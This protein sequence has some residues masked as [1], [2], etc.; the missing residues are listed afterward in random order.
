MKSNTFALKLLLILSLGISASVIQAEPPR[1][2]HMPYILFEP[3]PKHAPEERM[4]VCSAGG[5]AV[6]S[7]GRLWASWDSGDYGEGQENFILLATSGDGGHTWSEPK[8]IID[9]PF[10]ASYSMVWIDPNGRMWFVFNIWPIRSAVEDQVGMRERFDDIRSF[11]HFI[12]TYNFRAAQMW[13]ITTDNP[14]DEN[15]EWSS[16]RLIA[17]EVA[18][19]MNEPTVLSDG[20]WV[21]P[22]AP[23]R[24]DDFPLRPLFSSDEG[25]TFHFRG[26][27][28]IPQEEWN[29]F[30]N[31]VV[32]R[33]DGSLWLLTRI[34]SGIGESISH[35]QGKTWTPIR[36]PD[37]IAH[38]TSRLYISRLQSGNLLLVKHGDIM[39]RGR[40]ENLKAFIS[41]DDGKTWQGGFM[42]DERLGVTYPDGTQDKDGLIYVLY[43]Y[44]RHGAKEIL[45]AV[46]TEEDVLA[47]QAVS[48]KVRLR[49]VVDKALAFNP[50][51]QRGTPP[52]RAD[53]ILEDAPA[54]PRSEG[55]SLQTGPMAVL[56]PVQGEMRKPAVGAVIFN[57]RNHAFVSVPDSIAGH[58]FLYSPIEETEAVVSEAG[59]VYVLTP[60]PERNERGSL[61]RVLLER[62]FELTDVTEIQLFPGLG[63]RVSVYQKQVQAGERI[64]FGLWGVLIGK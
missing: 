62:G 57:N 37:N 1:W 11:N 21:W 51:H 23:L 55:V 54:S 20:T 27:V 40:R 19:H 44:D 60:R 36:N 45:M 35:D 3:L 53:F 26:H 47:G 10:R 13:A 22:T 5:I 7:N 32:E 25:E 39:E 41:K 61:E 30:E 48:G 34:R 49:Q 52:P 38:T 64:S 16:P 2:P 12:H 8:M 18:L 6:A 33:K 50:R 14:G 15:P 4:F 63:G 28:E 46:F 42:I 58:S 59:L 56:S 31:Q 9:P 24:K 29:A 17:T 43:D